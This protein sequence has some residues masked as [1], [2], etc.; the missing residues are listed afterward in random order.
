MPIREDSIPQYF[1][2]VSIK[3]VIGNGAT[4][5]F[6]IEPWFHG[7][8]IEDIAPHLVAVVPTR[9][10]KHRTV[11]SALCG[12]AWLQDVTTPL[13]LPMLTQYLQVREL[14]DMILLSEEEDKVI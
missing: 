6:W 11:H 7:C 10:R 4:T 2:K 8:S 9:R 5:L 3:I 12:N 14:I 13:T 1:F